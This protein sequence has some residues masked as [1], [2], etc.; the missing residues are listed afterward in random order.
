M[1]VKALI[2]GEWLEG[3]LIQSYPDGT[4][5]VSCGKKVYIVDRVEPA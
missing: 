4:H 2:D 1:K 3:F 5:R